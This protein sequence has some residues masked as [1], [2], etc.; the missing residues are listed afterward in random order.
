MRNV[1]VTGASRGLGLA[2]STAL[3]AE[4][5]QVL[6]VARTQSAALRS[7][8]AAPAGGA[9]H[10]RACDLAD[11]A[12]IPALVSGVRKEFGPLYGLVNNAGLGTSGVLALM[13]DE[14]IESLVRLNTV[15]PIV[16]TK[17]VVR[18]MM[19]EKRGASSTSPRSW[20]APAITGCRPTRPPRRRSWASRA[21]SRASWASS[22]SR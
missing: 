20:P 1:I 2:I 6:A 16:L 14:Q 7:L 13:R 3:A 10:F 12:A 11:L 18:S 17:Y 22:A 19:S 5:Y 4:G 9:V 15:S 21:H 8:A